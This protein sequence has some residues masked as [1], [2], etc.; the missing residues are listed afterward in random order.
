[1][2]NPW[3]KYRESRIVKITLEDFDM[4]ELYIKAMPIAAYGSHEMD[5]IGELETSEQHV[6][7]FKLWVEEWNI[8]DAEGE[9]VLPLPRDD[10]ENTW[11]KVIPGEIQVYI[12]KEITKVEEERMNL[13]PQIEKRQLQH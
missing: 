4:E 3:K 13:P 6:E 10:E 11:Q 5:R 12:M 8:P 7:M 1:M 9:E 2:T